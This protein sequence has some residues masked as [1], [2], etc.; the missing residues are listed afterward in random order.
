MSRS[1][2][3][4]QQCLRARGLLQAR[5]HVSAW[6]G[7]LGAKLRRKA[8]NG[9]AQAKQLKGLGVGRAWV[10]VCVRVD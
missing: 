2:S 9:R 7:V 1:S 4:T 3:S 8:V 10:C 5:L 6:L